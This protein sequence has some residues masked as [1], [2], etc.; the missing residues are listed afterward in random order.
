[1]KTNTIKNPMTLMTP[2]SKSE[3]AVVD[4]VIEEA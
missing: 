3:G 1:M 2:V 4:E